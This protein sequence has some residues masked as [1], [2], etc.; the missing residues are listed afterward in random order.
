MW[1]PAMSA[2]RLVPPAPISLVFW[3]LAEQLFRT[4]PPGSL[5]HPR[6]C[7]I[8]LCLLTVNNDVLLLVPSSW[9]TAP[10]NSS[11]S[12][13]LLGAYTGCF[14]CFPPTQR[15]LRVSEFFLG[16]Y[17][18]SSFTQIH[19]KM[20]TE[21]GW[22][23][24]W[25]W[26]EKRLLRSRFNLRASTKELGLGMTRAPV[27]CALP[28]QFTHRNYLRFFFLP[29]ICLKTRDDIILKNMEPGNNTFTP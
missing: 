29:S 22:F 15:A 2:S 9:S 5:G 4:Q 3:C 8:Q 18:E 23:L 28:A 20:A 7:S 13:S 6:S 14:M 19:R 25:W 10:S 21:T 12:P 17:R 27:C 26:W 24:W 11:F 16:S 1:L